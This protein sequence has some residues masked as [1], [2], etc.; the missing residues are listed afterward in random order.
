MALRRLRLPLLAIAALMLAGL[1]A[2]HAHLGH[3]HA[4]DNEFAGKFDLYIHR[5]TSGAAA[6]PVNLIFRSNNAGTVASTVAKVL[7]WNF[8]PGS[9]MSFIDAGATRPT[10]WQLGLDLG[11]GNRLHL[12]IESV[13]RADGQSYVLAAVHHDDMTGCGHIG[14]RFDD[15]RFAVVHAFVAQGYVVT[16]LPMKNTEPGAQCNGSRTAGDGTIA[17]IDLSSGTPPAQP[18][19]IPA[20]KL[21]PPIYIGM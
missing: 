13:T 7:G 14:G 18:P 6:D 8:V 9:G 3:A 17:V 1:L 15:A 11:W 12:R 10:T 21:L 5:S 4:S 20:G 19:L 2:I 16:R